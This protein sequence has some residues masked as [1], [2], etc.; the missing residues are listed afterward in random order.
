M[1]HLASSL[2][3]PLSSEVEE[4]AADLLAGTDMRQRE[5]LI[6]LHE[7]EE[8]LL[9]PRPGTAMHAAGAGA[10]PTW[11]AGPGGAGFRSLPATPVGTPRRV[12]GEPPGG[13]PRAAGIPPRA[14]LT[15]PRP[16]PARAPFIGGSAPILQAGR[17]S[18]RLLPAHLPPGSTLSSVGPDSS[19]AGS[20]GSLAGTSSLG[21]SPQRVLSPHLQGGPY[22]NPFRR[23]TPTP[24]ASA[25]A[26]P[27]ASPL[28]LG[29]GFAAGQALS[30]PRMQKP[31]GPPPP[32][33]L[34]AKQLEE[35]A[36]VAPPPTVAPLKTTPSA[37]LEGPELERLPAVAGEPAAPAGTVAAGEQGPAG[38]EPPRPSLWR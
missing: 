27:M 12:W 25:S 13:T 7:L 24:T 14:A 36:A 2:Q 3:Y 32:P 28:R 6:G 22:G 11:A 4:A 33:E 35:A 37:P 38:L 17:S 18:P 15:S 9:T 5:S 23:G 8:E 21:S 1:G 20:R 34:L 16:G 29:A 10:G 31:M 30:Q 26:S 19:A